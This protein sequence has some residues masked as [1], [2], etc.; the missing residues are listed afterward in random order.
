VSREQLEAS[1]AQVR[2]GVRDPRH[3][4]HGPGSA[5]WR[6]ERDGL[7]FVGGGRAALLQLAHPFVA[8]A[9]DQHSATRRD[10]VGRFQR[11]FRNVFAMSFGDL[12]DAFRAARRVHAIHSHIRGA[13]PEAIG[14]FPAGTVYHAND[15]DSLL[16]V[17][18]TLV[19]TV[20]A[21]SE[22]VRGPLADGDKEAYYRASGQFA[23]L[24]GIPDALRPPDWPSFRRYV[25]DMLASPILTVAP[26]ARD[27]A[28][29]LFGRGPGQRQNRV[30]AAVEAI[31]AALLPARLRDEFGLRYRGADRAFAAV[32]LA[33]LRPVGRAVPRRLRYLPAYV[34]AARRIRGQPPSEL[35][36][37]LEQRMFGVAG[38]ITGPAH[39]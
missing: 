37:W 34:A 15:A 33:S 39:R 36:A 9:V 16:W 27:M 24:F 5:A 14:P 11:T 2:A 17:Y 23:R 30:G 1:L 7:I 8:Y 25:D 10:V 13:F 31:T 20:V 12:D 19:D 28:A 29:F 26:P 4:I 18:A 38:A 6:L 35:A 3:G 22:R 32:A 21:I